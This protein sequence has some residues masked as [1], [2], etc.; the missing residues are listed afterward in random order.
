MI[1]SLIK[2][3]CKELILITD[4]VYTLIIF[5]IEVTELNS[6]DGR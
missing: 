6:Q 5:H 1:F 2:I 3:A 4:D